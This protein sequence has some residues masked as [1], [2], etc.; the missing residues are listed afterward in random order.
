M[1]ASF[2]RGIPASTREGHRP[3]RQLVHAI[4]CVRAACRSSTS[5]GEHRRGGRKRARH[6][7]AHRLPLGWP[8]SAYFSARPRFKVW[9]L[10]HI[11]HLRPAVPVSR[12]IPRVLCEDMSI[13]YCLVYVLCSDRERGQCLFRQDWTGVEAR[14]TRMDPGTGSGAHHMVERRDLRQRN[15]SPAERY[16]KCR[17]RQSLPPATGEAT[18][19]VSGPFGRPKCHPTGATGSGNVQ[20]AT[21]RDRRKRFSLLRRDGGPGETL[22]F[23]ALQTGLSTR[24]QEPKGCC[25]RL[26]LGPWPEAGLERQSPG[27]AFTSTNRSF[28][29]RRS[30]ARRA[31]T[32]ALI[33]GSA[34]GRSRHVSSRRSRHGH[35]RSRH[36]RCE[37][38]ALNHRCCSVYDPVARHV[39]CAV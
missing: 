13:R 9:H 32:G 16:E 34:D 3:F 27:C 38:I 21:G 31:S 8:L 6:R 26:T 33:A 7:V 12:P 18:A 30:R 35:H 11:A 20:L 14:G 25:G 17:H 29:Q 36:R 37:C 5:P 23:D 10:P 2:V 28:H 22:L 1:P 24:S 39:R 4:A 15:R 19:I